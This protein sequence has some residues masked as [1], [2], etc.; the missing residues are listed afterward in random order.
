MRKNKLSQGFSA[1]LIL[2]IAAVAIGA[3]VAFTL[4]RNS[5]TSQTGTERTTG[6]SSEEGVPQGETESTIPDIVGRGQNLECDWKMPT[7]G[8]ENPFGAGKLYTTGNKGRSQ[9]AGGT[10]GVAIEGNAIYKDGEVYSWISAAGTTMGFKFTKDELES[11]NAEMTAEQKQ[12]AEQIRQQMIFN[13]KPWTPDESK[14]VLPSGV[15]FR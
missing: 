5:T 11:M 8:T 15:E 13:C 7:T 9:I 2:V 6:A 4:S 10:E 14:F 12:Q 1:V 3:V